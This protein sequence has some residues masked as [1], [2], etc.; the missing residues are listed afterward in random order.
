MSPPNYA[1]FTWLMEL[2]DL[3]RPGNLEVGFKGRP[4][5]IEVGFLLF[6]M[7]VEE[8]DWSA[9]IDVGFARHLALLIIAGLRVCLVSRIEK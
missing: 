8:Y 7:R 6:R 1:Q 5:G 2:R 9:E 4:V 3:A